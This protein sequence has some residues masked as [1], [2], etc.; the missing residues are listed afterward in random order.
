MDLGIT[1]KV[2]MV[3]AASKGLG[4]AAAMEL[5]RE[6]AHVSICARGPQIA[7]VAEEIRQSTRSKVLGVQADLAKAEDIDRFIRAT[8][9][10]F[11]SIDILVLN[12]GGPPPGGFLDLKPDA[13]ETAFELT[14]MSAVRLCRGVI[15]H[16]LESGGGS[17]VAIQSY[18]VKQPVEGLILSNSLRLA[19][20]SLMESLSQEFGPKG[21]RVNWI[22][23]YFTRTERVEQL[24]ADRAARK[25]ST[26]EQ[27]ATEIT[28]VVPLGRMGTVEEFGRAV[29]FLAAP[30]SEGISGH[31]LMFDGGAVKTP[32]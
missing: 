23:P 17:I 12:A 13:W 14:V 22:N 1:G 28:R 5:A 25:G 18:S 30:A 16:M 10:E 19:V 9:T 2:A 31:G 6:G 32:L 26:V 20:V 4:K 7:Q 27:E 24:L 8:L 15:P 11:G 29:A 21:I 3:A